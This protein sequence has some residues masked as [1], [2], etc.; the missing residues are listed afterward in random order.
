[1]VELL[2]GGVSI[3]ALGDVLYFSWNQ[4]WMAMSLRTSKTQNMQL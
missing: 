3:T 1:M 4:S 2:F